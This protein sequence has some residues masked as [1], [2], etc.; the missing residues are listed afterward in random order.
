MSRFLNTKKDKHFT[1]EI[2]SEAFKKTVAKD[3][4]G[5]P[6]IFSLDTKTTIQLTGANNFSEKIILTENFKYNNNEDK[7]EIRRYE[8]EI[9]ENLAQ[10]IAKD[11]IFKLSNSK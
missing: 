6:S 2:K 4:K 8:R 3:S 10:K 9:K 5:D 1:L 7:F 11:L